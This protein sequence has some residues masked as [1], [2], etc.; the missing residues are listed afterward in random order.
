[1]PA[2]R[3]TEHVAAG[4]FKRAAEWLSARPQQTLSD[5]V[6]RAQ[7][8]LEI[9]DTQSALSQAHALLSERLE[10]RLRAI[11][12]NIAGRALSRLGAVRE[13]I[14]YQRK[15]VVLAGETDP[16]LEP[17]ILADLVSALLNWVG[18]EPALAELPRLR[19]LALLVGNTRALIDYH[20]SSARIATMRGWLPRATREARIALDLLDQFPNTIQLW[21]VKQIQSNVAI[22]ACDMP[23]ARAYAAECLNLAEQ[24][25]SRLSIGTTLG[26]LAH[27]ASTTGDFGAGRQILERAMESLDPASHMRIAAFSTG[28]EIGLASGDTEFAEDMLSHRAQLEIPASNEGRYYDLWFELNNVKWLV[29][30][31]HIDEALACA[32]DALAS[33]EKLADT[34]LLDRMT[35]I[36][37][38]CHAR[39]GNAAAASHL[40]AQVCGR[41]QHAS[42]ET[43]AEL[44]RVAAVISAEDNRATSVQFL[45]RAWRILTEAG[46]LGIRE[47]VSRTSRFLGVECPSEFAEACPVTPLD[48]L[49]SSA[50][51]LFLNDHP[52]VLAAEMDTLL[53]GV[54]L[55]RSSCL[56]VEQDGI[57]S[58]AKTYPMAPATGDVG[59]CTTAESVVLGTQHGR[60]YTLKVVTKP[61][62][63]ASLDWSAVAQLARSAE[64]TRNRRAS[65]EQ[66]IVLW[67][68]ETPEQ[69]LG[70]V[71]V[72]NNMLEV[73][74]TSRRLAPSKIPVLIL[75]A[76]AA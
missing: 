52:R 50:T 57:T 44:N 55:A 59:E 27:I 22:K 26:N 32:T 54:A 42:L 56:D 71:V 18:I 73:V 41:L 63:L 8:E 70:M 39:K 31:G 76:K 74:N 25:G 51:I 72:A 30:R 5:R 40:F 53:R 69:Q 33:I 17:E 13:G 36:A 35:L 23:A 46:L 7:I 28:I 3:I 21:K 45:A 11:C 61:S 58:H 16:Q 64:S 43:L 49:R 48:C 9:G 29:F 34:D 1:M 24:S 47:D 19:R 67:P 65:D 6:L 20:I 37:A 14:G 38:E 2:N 10:P 12:L 68:E 60:T 62:N 4:D 75:G 15:A 66:Q